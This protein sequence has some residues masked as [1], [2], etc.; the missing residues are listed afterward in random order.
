MTIRNFIDENSA[1]LSS[2]L[3]PVMDI[4]SK[5]KTVSDA[6]II[7]DFTDCHVVS[8]LFVL[9]LLV[10]QSHT[11]KDIIFTGKNDYL[12][13]IGLADGGIRPDTLRRSEFLAVME[14]Y[15]NKDY[16]PIVNFPAKVEDDEKEAVSS[17]VESMLIRQNGIESNVAT[18]LK[19]IIEETLDNVTEHSQTDRGYIF[20]Q[21]QKERGYLDICIADRG[22]T[23]LGSYQRLPDNEIASDLEAI[24]AANR[25]ISSKN[26][27]EAENRGYGIYTSKKMLIEGLRG[28]YLM[29]S[30]S[31]FYMKGL[32]YDK[33]H[34][35]P[36]GLHWDGTIVAFRLPFCEPKFN[37]INFI[38]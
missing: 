14:G 36:M 37:Y 19:Y 28:Q 26:L 35:L 8:P 34:E 29:I 23:L 3:A 31:T 9:S 33:F 32:C 25:G 10:F 11:E 6:Q 13:S 1:R 20:A 24:K 38:E 16:I 22:I 2:G 18:G 4:M 21:S 17:I 5:V 12:K 7:L 15:A 27:P 30:G